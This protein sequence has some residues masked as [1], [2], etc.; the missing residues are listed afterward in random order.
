MALQVLFKAGFPPIKTVGD[1]GAHGAGITGIHGIG[2]RVPRAAAVAAATVGLAIDWHMPK[3]IMFTMGT[4][5]IM[6]AA[7]IPPAITRA[8]GSTIKVPGAIPKEHLIAAPAHT[9]NPMLV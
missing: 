6:V 2:V 4:L 3:G 8:A 1:P 7:G 9:Q 5:S